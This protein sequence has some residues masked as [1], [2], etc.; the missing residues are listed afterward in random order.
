MSQNV[1]FSTATSLRLPKI[2]QLLLKGVTQEDIAKQ[3]KVNRRTIV[4][5]IHTWLR[6]GNF[7]E[8]LKEVWLDLYATSR[9]DDPLTTFKEINRLVARRSIQR[10]EITKD[11]REETHTT[12]DVTVYNHA[13]QSILDEAARLLVATSKNKPG[14]IH[15]T[16]G[17]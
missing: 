1:S 9:N 16:T 11:T 4:R 3:L 5:D 15:R 14:D 8:W 7:D 10:Q 2:K 17:I 12:I 13:Q 6:Y